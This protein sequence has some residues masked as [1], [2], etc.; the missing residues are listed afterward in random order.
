M[1]QAAGAFASAGRSAQN[2]LHQRFRGECFERGNGSRKGEFISIQAIEIV[3]RQ[4]ILANIP[5]FLI[6]Q[7]IF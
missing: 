4:G 2:G 5:Q 6:S 7:Q 3:A 1:P